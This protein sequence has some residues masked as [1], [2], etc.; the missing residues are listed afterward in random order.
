MSD[1]VLIT[2]ELSKRRTRASNGY[3]EPAEFGKLARHCLESPDD[4][5]EALVESAL[6]LCEAHSA[7]VSLLEGQ[8]D[9]ARFRCVTAVGRYRAAAMPTVPRIRSVS[10]LVLTSR[11][12]QLYRAP[13]RTF[14]A[15]RALDPPLGEILLAPLQ[16]PDRDVGTIWIVRHDDEPHFDRADAVRLSH[17]ATL[18]LTAHE[19]KASRRT[20]DEAHSARALSDRRM[21]L[22]WQAAQILLTADD[23]DRMLHAL[24]AEVRAELSVDTYFNF[25]VNEEGEA[26]ALASCVGIPDDEAR[27]IQRLDFGQ[28]ICGR[29]AQDRVAIVATDIQNSDDP[30]VQLVKGYGIRA[31]ACN[32][33]MSGEEL[34]GTLSFASHER[35]YFADEEL[36]CIRVISR[37]VAV[38]Y[39]RL[40]L[41]AKLRETDRRKDEFLATLAHE[42]RNP[43]API[44]SAV[45]FTRIKAPEDP[46]LKRALDIVDRQLKGMVRL[47]DDLLDVS[48]ITLG[49]I[50]LQKAPVSLGVVL[51]HAIEAA[52][53]LIESA[54]HTL[55]VE[56][57]ED[58]LELEADATRLSQVFLNLLNNAAKYTPPGGCIDMRVE[59]TNQQAL[60]SIRDSGIGI[61]KTML[62]HVF[63]LFAQANR[64][65]GTVQGGLG[66]G[67]TLARRLVQLH[68]GAI[69][70]RSDGEHQG[71]EFLVRLPL[72]SRS[73]AKG[74][75]S[76]RIGMLA[77]ARRR[78][79]IVDDNRDASDSLAMLL[80]MLEQEVRVAYD[81]ETAI[82]YTQEFSPDLILLDL[83]MPGIDGYETCRRLR[84]QGSSRTVTIVAL[85]GW[86]QARDRLQTQEAGFDLHWTKPLDMG[87]LENFLH[88]AVVDR[89]PDAIRKP[90]R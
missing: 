66:I 85:T 18:F 64:V 1:T 38:A 19:L 35:N 2:E 25:M 74:G 82:R 44:R 41:I 34:L 83:G 45:E 69:E 56:L 71:S 52:K 67:L 48:R 24:F 6:R 75:Q 68:G 89:A 62:T 58:P 55:R 54:A 17:L 11:T 78:I 72:H 46:S 61:P 76:E 16:L 87:V 84:A 59:V 5:A 27:K 79:L 63:D 65:S 42:L 43:L 60:V 14:N 36:D 9:E 50:E 21:R 4:A 20:L 51:S 32:P 28:A 8:S 26:L 13:G 7:G 30:K 77:P 12:A 31:Y 39:E 80:Q 70:A 37:Y 47:V 10:D 29:V 86:G 53:P 57:P 3:D 15:F 88:G 40:R 22:L 90:D 23:P 81:G 73:Q 33:L 49:R